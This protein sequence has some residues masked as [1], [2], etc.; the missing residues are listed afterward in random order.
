MNAMLA[1]AKS[2]IAQLVAKQREVLAPTLTRVDNLARER[3]NRK[4]R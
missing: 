3:L 4:F 1:L 2:G